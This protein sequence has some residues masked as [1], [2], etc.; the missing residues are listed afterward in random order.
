M[1]LRYSLHLIRS[2]AEEARYAATHVGQASW[3]VGPYRC[4]E[5]AWFA[6]AAP[7][8]G[9]CVKF[10]RLM[11]ADGIRIPGSALS[12]RFFEPAQSETALTEPAP[13]AA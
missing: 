7:S 13:E 1:L 3:A 8:T 11:D 6:D 10:E 12:C 9:V 4:A 5:C 2:P